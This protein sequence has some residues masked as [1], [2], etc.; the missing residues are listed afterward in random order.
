M[1]GLINMC[2]H[3]RV[4]NYNINHK[5]LH[6]SITCRT[7]F[8]IGKGIFGN[9]CQQFVAHAGMLAGPIKFKLWLITTKSMEKSHDQKSREFI[10]LIFWGEKSRT[11]SQ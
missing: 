9:C 10:H 8:M 5:Q 4:H 11:F 1:L 3:A 6:V 2:I 7:F